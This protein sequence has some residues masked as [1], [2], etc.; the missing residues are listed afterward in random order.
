MIGESVRRVEDPVLLRGRGAFVDDLS[1]PG[2]LHMR[3]VRAPVAHGRVLGIDVSAA[4]DSPGVVAVWT[5][6]DV[7][8]LPPIDFRMS[9]RP[10]LL[11]YR[12]RVLA[13]GT[14]RYVGEP[15]A[16]VFATSPYDAEDGA[17]L[18]D[19]Q[20]ESLVPIVRL[21]EE[22]RPWPVD[23]GEEGL[24]SQA[25]VF[26]NGYGDVDA[27]FAAAHHVVEVD[28]RIG[29]HTGV[30]LEC[31]GLLAHLDEARGV[32]VLEGAAKVPFWNRD[33]IARMVGMPP[34]R[35]ALHEGH[36]GGGFGVRGELY[37]EDVLVALG[38]VRLGRPVKWIEDRQ[39]HLVATNHSRDQRH[40]LRAAVMDDGMVTA[41]DGEFW[42]D[43]G[44]YQRTHAA[45][46]SML[47][48]AMLP[49]PYKVPNYRVRARI[50]MTHKT[51]AGT[52]R[53]PGRYEG[54]FARERLMDKVALTLGMERLDVRRHNFIPVAQMPWARDL[55]VL[56]TE[57]VY[58]S[59]DY[60][61]LLD[62]M[63]AHWDL[64]G[65]AATV[66]R[67]RAAG[68]AVGIGYGCFVEKS[69]LG[70]YEGTRITVDT[71]GA[72]SVFSGAS[73]VGQ[74]IDTVLSQVVGG[75]LGLGEE[76][77]RIVRGETDSFDYGGGAFATRLSVMAG[78]AALRAGE[79]LRE[80][81]LRVAAAV[82]EIDE[83]DLELV[84]GTVRAI[85]DPGVAL[86]LAEIAQACDPTNARR[87]GVE[88]GLTAAGWFHTEHMTYPY[89][90][91]VAV[92]RIDEG[93]GQVVPE[94]YL[95]GYDI[96][97]AL[98]P[99]LVEGQIAGGAVQGIGGALYE[100]FLYSDE[101]QPLCT[102]FMD[103]LLPTMADVPPIEVLVTEDAPSPL[104]PLGVKGAGEGGV[105]AAAAAIASAIDDAL[106]RTACVTAVPVT[107]NAVRQLLR[108]EP[109]TASPTST[110]TTPTRRTR[111]RS[112]SSS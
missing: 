85:G 54:T 74:G 36:V 68:E 99:M 89:G 28:V 80:K 57:L 65:L 75:V 60:G 55:K 108:S 20:I 58:D 64:P 86:S 15:V 81:A 51:P 44:A 98:N 23:S 41:L 16:V 37:P 70:P 39:E 63:S 92:V 87:L 10:E 13:A 9:A 109:R 43:Q 1:R 103:Y 111:A 50:R 52:Y 3:V 4:L 79:A 84:D 95:V 42:L 24:T 5:H 45:T 93:T 35:V 78:S 47:T 101:G 59:G 96:G 17:D 76:R 106:Q 90:V 7:E 33:A 18:V 91:H 88:P 62:R 83:R 25:S 19:L 12:Q 6:T 100:C 38:A 34:S 27:A 11:P 22:P 48:G 69:G 21:D 8:S 67:R 46:V 110:R 112:R 2:Q 30:P 53:S 40:R 105:T 29:R 102:T 31:R 82:F 14:V 49:G 94:R 26:E 56:G 107:P 104:N 66:A 61:L 71:D 32:L 72:V 77:I 73:S 97:K